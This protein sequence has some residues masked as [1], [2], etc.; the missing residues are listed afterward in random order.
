MPAPTTSRGD[1][2]SQDLA[3]LSGLAETK[4]SAAAPERY[5]LGL[6]ASMY[7]ELPLDQAMAHVRKAGY[8]HIC[9]GRAHAGEFV[10]SPKLPKTECTRLLHRIRGLGVEPIMSLG[11]SALN[12]KVMTD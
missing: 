12:L 3:A 11:G 8:R 6:N 4:P 2:F 10:Y 9:I 1:T 5:K 7:S